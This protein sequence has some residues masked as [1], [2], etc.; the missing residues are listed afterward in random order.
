MSLKPA[1]A[2]I[3]GP[4]PSGHITYTH[5]AG[6]IVVADEGSSFASGTVGSC[7]FASFASCCFVVSKSNIAIFAE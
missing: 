4:D 6:Q 7:S 5:S 2:I 3:V 1:D